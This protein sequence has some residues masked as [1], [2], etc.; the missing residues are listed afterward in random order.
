MNFKKLH[1]VTFFLF[2]F[3]DVL[4]VSNCFKN[5]F[6]FQLN[7]IWLIWSILE[8]NVLNDYF[9]IVINWS[10]WGKYALEFFDSGDE[11]LSWELLILH[12]CWKLR[13]KEIIF[14]LYPVSICKTFEQYALQ[15]I[16]TI[17]LIKIDYCKLYA[18]YY[19]CYS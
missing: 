14:N 18:R 13:A 12:T 8:R 11:E 19:C 9:T 1:P 6:L 10:L 7:F 4:T 17:S 15:K 3:I 2:I 5:W 16:L